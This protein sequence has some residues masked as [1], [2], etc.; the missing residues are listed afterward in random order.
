MFTITFKNESNVDWTSKYV[1]RTFDD[2]EQ[3][4]INDKFTNKGGMFE[5]EGD[6]WNFR[7]RAY[8]EPREVYVAKEDK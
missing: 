6:G 7:L 1:F 8:I 3:Y 4:L 2:A 5:R